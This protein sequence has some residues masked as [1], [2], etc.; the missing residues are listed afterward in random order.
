MCDRNAHSRKK[1]GDKNKMLVVMQWQLDS[2]MIPRETI[3]P[4]SLRA[5]EGENERY[6]DGW[7]R[8]R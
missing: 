2:G 4:L 1:P 7:T 8:A 6:R 5:I 3:L